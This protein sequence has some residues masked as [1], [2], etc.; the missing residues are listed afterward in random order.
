MKRFLS[1]IAALFTAAALTATMTAGCSNSTVTSDSTESGSSS[2]KQTVSVALWGSALLETYAPW[3]Q[4][5]YP[6][7]EF[8]FYLGNNSTDYYN[9]CAEKD[10]LPDILTVRRFAL[11][12]V[13]GI[14]NKLIDLSNTELANSFYQSYIKSYTYSDGTINW[15]PACAEIDDILIN[16]TLFEE[17]GIAI[18]TDYES[19]VEACKAFEAIGITGYAAD[20]SMDYTCMMMLQG[21][22]TAELTSADGRQW[23]QEYESNETNQLSESVWLSAFNKLQELIDNDLIQ[24]GS[25]DVTELTLAEDFYDGKVAMMR[26]TG[27]SVANYETDYEIEMI[28]YLGDT[29]E[30]SWYLTYPSFQA[31]AKLEGNEDPERQELLIDIMTTMLSEE[32]LKHIATGQNTVAYNKDVELEL[33]DELSSVKT[34]ISE[35]KMY[36]RIASSDMFSVSKTVVTKMLSGEITSGKDAFDAFNAELAGKSAEEAPTVMHLDKTYSHKF[37]A[38]GGNEAASALYNTLREELGVDCVIGGSSIIGAD[39]LEGDYTAAEAKYVTVGWDDG[40]LLKYNLTGAQLKTAVQHLLDIK[41]TRDSVSGNST[42]PAASGFEMEITRTD[43]GYTLDNITING[44]DIG[45]DTTYSVVI[46][47]N[48]RPNIGDLE[49]AGFTDYEILENNLHTT[50]AARLIDNA[51]Q[52]AEPTD[53]ITLHE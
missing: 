45:D 47:V 26:A 20:F 49:E 42:L 13:E 17:N 11:R 15:L 40:E 50:I 28:P 4:E 48:Y 25:S 29:E 37:K 51:G 53:Y 22:A 41:G 44:E 19:F 34:Y 35:N 9:Y 46:R 21:L 5:Q 8:D 7:V 3:L 31:A 2:G 10:I 14:R 6:D 18:P 38:D 1:K 43:S 32:G 24:P 30:D 52:F 33:M 23:R 12:D 27:A 39:I 16:K 36:I